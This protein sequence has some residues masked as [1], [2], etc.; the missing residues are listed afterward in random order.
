[1]SKVLDVW[2]DLELKVLTEVFPKGGIRC[3]RL[4]GIQKSDLDIA[5]K[6]IELRLETTQ[7]M[8]NPTSLEGKISLI[9][10]GIV[11]PKGWSKGDLQIVI[12]FYEKGGLYLCKEQGIT[13]SD[14][15]IRK[16]ARELGLKCVSKIN[17]NWSYSEIEFIKDN[18]YKLSLNELSEA[19]QTKSYYSIRS[20]LNQLGLL[21]GLSSW[22]T[23]DIEI[24]EK[25]YP[26]GGESL[27]QLKGVTKHTST[28]RS[29]AIKLRLKYLKVTSEWT[30]EEISI[31][32]KYYPIEGI[33]VRLRLYN[34]DDKA[35]YNKIQSFNLRKN[36]K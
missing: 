15:K 30:E 4:S 36:K 6:A 10:E 35:I 16:L 11:I 27:V 23:E 14:H 31:L 5:K 29:K 17:K 1:M 13:Q 18:Y 24:L 8:L 9:K 32:K 25:Y 21:V 33:K 34:K 26:I 3:V 19:L 2:T 22:S 12:D 20:K 28:I 7:P